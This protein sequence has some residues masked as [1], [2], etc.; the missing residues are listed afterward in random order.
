[1]TN[2]V[3]F[4]SG[5]GWAAI[6]ISNCYCKGVYTFL[7]IDGI[8][9]MPCRLS[10]YLAKLFILPVLV[11]LSM[12]GQASNRHENKWN[13]PSWSYGVYFWYGKLLPLWWCIFIEQLWVWAIVVP[14]L[15][16]I[17]IYII[18]IVRWTW[19]GVA[20]FISPEL[21]YIVHILS[22]FWWRRPANLTSIFCFLFS[23]LF[24][25]DQLVRW[26]VVCAGPVLMWRGAPCFAPWGKLLVECLALTRKTR[27]LLP[28]RCVRLKFIQEKGAL[29]VSE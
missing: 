26:V 29:L 27:V 17:P 3:C 2:Y 8:G 12:D 10:F 28:L 11:C 7:A 20:A 5:Q 13:V 19:I 1:M 24:F 15:N 22:I 18:D 4:Q 21:W 23:F 14:Y 9:S 16:Q 6:I 25:S